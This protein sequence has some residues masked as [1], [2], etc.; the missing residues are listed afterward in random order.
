MPG[1]KADCLEAL[2]AHVCV[3]T[4]P[5]P[6]TGEEQAGVSSPL[7]WTLSLVHLFRGQLAQ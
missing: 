2:P 4:L 3:L 5:P 1:R 7:L 6:D